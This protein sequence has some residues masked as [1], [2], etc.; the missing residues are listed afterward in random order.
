MSTTAVTPQSLDLPTE[1]ARAADL[2][3]DRKAVDVTLLDL[4]GIS[5]ATDFFLVATGTS[6]THV[7]AISDHVVEELRTM[8]TRPMNVEGARGGRWILIDY[9]SF[10]VHVFHPAAREFYQLERLWGD[11]PTHVL[12]PAEGAGAR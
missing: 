3:F 11:A 7:S 1:V 2:L 4:R 5:S 10:V 9:F 6:D 8:G 12:A